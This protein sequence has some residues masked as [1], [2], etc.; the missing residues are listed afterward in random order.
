MSATTCTCGPAPKF[1]FACSGGSD[2]G[3]LTDLAAREMTRLGLGRMYCLAGVAGRVPD[4]TENTQAAA[5]ILA[6]DGCPKDCT[7]KTLELAGITKF[8]HLR[9][10]DLGFSKGAAPASTENLAK[11]I[12]KGQELLGT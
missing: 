1:V 12:A 3:A 7:K 5:A 10:S 6:I 9:L 4:I 8:A 11:V 2:V